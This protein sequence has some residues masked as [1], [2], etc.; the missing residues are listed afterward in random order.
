MPPKKAGFYTAPKIKCALCGDDESVHRSD[1]AWI[2]E[3]FIQYDDAKNNAASGCS[4]STH[5]P[6][7]A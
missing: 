1:T 5:A 2:E 6:G 3:V 4:A 7:P